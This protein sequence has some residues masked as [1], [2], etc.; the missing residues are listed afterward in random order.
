MNQQAAVEMSDSS[1]QMVSGASE[2]R[3]FE[4]L[5]TA[6]YRRLLKIAY[7]VVRDAA[8]AQDLAQDACALLWQQRA[9]VFALPA[10]ERWLLKTCWLM[11]QNQ[12]RRQR[13]QGVRSNILRAEGSDD[14]DLALTAASTND[15]VV[16]LTARRLWQALPEEERELLWLHAVAGCSASELGDVLGISDV[17]VRKRLQRVRASAVRASGD[18]AFAGVAL[19]AMATLQRKAVTNVAAPMASLVWKLALAAAL[20]AVPI[21]AYVV[22]SADGNA[23]DDMVAAS[24]QSEV[25]GTSPASPEA[26]GGQKRTGAPFLGAG[27]AFDDVA[28]DEPTAAAEVAH[29]ERGASPQPRAAATVDLNFQD[30]PVEDIIQLLADVIGPTLVNADMS[31]TISVNFRNVIALD[32]LDYVLDAIGATRSDTLQYAL[33]EDAAVFECLLAGPPRTIAFA[34]AAFDSLI[35]LL[36][37][38]ALVMTAQPTELAGLRFT[39][40]FVN[41]SPSDVLR[42]TLRQ[43][44]VGC[45]AEHAY[46]IVAR[47]PE[48]TRP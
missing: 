12:R 10:P 43:A 47:T 46:L 28:A 48:G 37:N 33:V 34:D 13:R 11:A 31:G 2:A 9:A 42:A 32:A 1:E 24:D 26:A 25:R 21:T 20:I 3:V 18:V 41:T 8:A 39:G 23:C 27:R 29:G 22:T 17:A 6:E 44:G 4:A 45:R 5:V 30:A 35:K 36:T 40:N 38:G 14:R 15:P 7:A 19:P 16:E